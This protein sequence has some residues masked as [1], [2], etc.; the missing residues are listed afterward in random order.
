MSTTTTVTLSGA[1]PSRD[2]FTRRSA[3]C[4]APT[5]A[6]ISSRI[7]SNSTTPDR[8]SEQSIQRSPGRVS[9]IIVSTSGED[10]TSPSTRMSTERRGC[11]IA[12]SAVMRPASTSRCTKVWSVEIW[13]SSPERSR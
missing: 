9:S 4:L 8:P 13:L 10:S 2:A 1:P 7:S 12:S 6:D 3:T 11:T 5:S